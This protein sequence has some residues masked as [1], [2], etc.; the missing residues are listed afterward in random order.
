MSVE[1]RVTKME[2]GL[3]LQTVL[4][5]IKYNDKSPWHFVC[6]GSIC[7]CHRHVSLMGPDIT[8]V[9]DANYEMWLTQVYE[10]WKKAGISWNW[11]IS[12][13]QHPILLCLGD[14]GHQRLGKDLLVN[15]WL[16]LLL[17]RRK[18]I[19]GNK[20]T[21]FQAVYWAKAL[22]LFPIPIIPSMS[23]PLTLTG[24]FPFSFLLMLVCLWKASL[25]CFCFCFFMPLLHNIFKYFHYKLYPSS[26][27]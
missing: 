9:R 4:L 3:W 11:M 20:V 16:W 18:Q 24:C 21:G 14:V 19:Q 23:W 22:G 15:V 5:S 8:A 27:L 26:F 13:L 17:A 12:P 2:N 25:V 6:H 10:S 1:I 7:L